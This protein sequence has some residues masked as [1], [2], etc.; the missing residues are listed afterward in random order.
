LYYDKIVTIT[1]A[2]TYYK[3]IPWIV[4][5]PNKNNKDVYSKSNKP[6]PNKHGMLDLTHIRIG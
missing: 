4:N 2:F 5:K 3:Q 1:L 6:H